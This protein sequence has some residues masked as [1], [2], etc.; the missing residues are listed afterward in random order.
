[1]RLAVPTRYSG[2][3]EGAVRQEVGELHGPQ[4]PL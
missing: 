2:S 1:M 3:F 4:M